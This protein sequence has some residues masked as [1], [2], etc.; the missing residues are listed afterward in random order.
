MDASGAISD[1]EWGERVVKG[2]GGSVISS[3]RVVPYQLLIW[4]ISGTKWFV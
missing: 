2:C 1:E 3:C 4:V